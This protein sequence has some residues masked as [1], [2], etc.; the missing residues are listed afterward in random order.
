[1]NIYLNKEQ[2]IIHRL[3]M[4]SN[5]CQDT[6]LFYGKTGIMLFFMRYYQYTNNSIFEDVAF[7]L[8]DEITNNLNESL[9]INFESGLCG[10]AWAINYLIEKR[11]IEGDS[12]EICEDIDNKIMETDPCRLS[13]YSLEKGLGGILLY[14]LAHIKLVHKQ[15]QKYPFDSEYMHDLYIACSNIRYNKVLSP[16]VMNLLESYIAFYTKNKLPDDSV[17]SLSV[18]VKEISDFEE[19][20][21]SSYLLGLRQGLSGVL[22][23][24]LCL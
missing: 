2:R 17:W 5:I 21:I 9:S 6:G 12:L 14:V 22:F 4:V 24:D 11:N 20:K 10:I 19:Q 8:L 1:M 13:D 7:D 16:I 15:R 18:V 3:L 23:K